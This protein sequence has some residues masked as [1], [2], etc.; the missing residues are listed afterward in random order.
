MSQ[1]KSKTVRVGYFV[2]FQPPVVIHMCVL[3]LRP[4]MAPLRERTQHVRNLYYT[5]DAAS[6]KK[7]TRRKQKKEREKKKD[8][9]GGIQLRRDRQR[10]RV[11]DKQS[12]ATFQP[13]RSRRFVLN[14][15]S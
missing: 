10:Q 14:L 8:G 3:I 5:S 4:K 13:G 9:D 6:K 1:K 2:L 12:D 7:K 11:D 15:R